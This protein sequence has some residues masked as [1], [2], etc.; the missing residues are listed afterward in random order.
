MLLERRFSPSYR[1][2]F[3]IYNLATARG[4]FFVA[5][6]G[7]CYTQPH[8]A[9]RLTPSGLPDCSALRFSHSKGKR[10]ERR[11]DR[12]RRPER[13]PEMGDDPRHRKR[14]NAP[15]GAGGNRRTVPVGIHEAAFFR[16]QAA[17]GSC[18]PEYRCGTEADRRPAQAQFRDA[19]AG[20][21]S[22]GYSGTAGGRPAESGLGHPENLAAVSS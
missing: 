15:H 13:R 20:E 4:G 17:G 2:F 5:G 21:S 14:K 7:L 6:W 11:K 10:H 3:Y 12:R 22:P 18:R 1:K 9:R 8:P 19:S 16:R